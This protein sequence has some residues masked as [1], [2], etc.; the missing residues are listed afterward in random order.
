MYWWFRNFDHDDPMWVPHIVTHP[1]YLT[2]LADFFIKVLTYCD[3]NHGYHWSPVYG[4]PCI[5]YMVPFSFYSAPSRS[6]S[7]GLQYEISSSIFSS[8]FSPLCSPHLPWLDN[9]GW[10]T[11]GSWI[12]LPQWMG[13]QKNRWKDSFSDPKGQPEGS[14]ILFGALKY[15]YCK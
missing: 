4:W 13:V 5:V 3:L 14:N 1:R 11:S 7:T 2:S 8:P 6:V 12:P 9:W 10:Q 15:T